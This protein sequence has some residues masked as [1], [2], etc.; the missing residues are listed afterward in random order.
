MG[1]CVRSFVHVQPGVAGGAAAGYRRGGLSQRVQQRQELARHRYQI[2]VRR[3][4]GCRQKR[5]L[6]GNESFAY[7]LCPERCCRLRPLKEL[8]WQQLLSS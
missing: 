8:L 7:R 4:P 5:R 6:S 2:S 3:I 1:I